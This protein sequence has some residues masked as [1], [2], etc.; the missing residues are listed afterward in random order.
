[1]KFGIERKLN[2]YNQEKL[3][4]QVRK[5]WYLN[6]RDLYWGDEKYYEFYQVEFPIDRYL[7]AKDFI[8]ELEENQLD[9]RR[10]YTFTKIFGN[11]FR[12]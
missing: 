4:I 6:W 9:Q 10:Y 11:V 7:Q 5:W 8:K 2:N 3:I 1:M 12:L